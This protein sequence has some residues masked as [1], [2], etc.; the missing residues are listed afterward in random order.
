M[1]TF[2][3]CVMMFYLFDHQYKKSRKPL[4]FLSL[5]QIYINYQEKK[6]LWRRVNL[7]ILGS[8]NC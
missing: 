8:A 6:R 7:W 4:L 1:D 5:P 3:L 2:Y